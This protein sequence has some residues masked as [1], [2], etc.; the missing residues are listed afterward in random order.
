MYLNYHKKDIIW[1]TKKR[2][3]VDNKEG[4]QPPKC[5]SQKK[6]KKKTPNTM[7]IAVFNR[8]VRTSPGW[9]LVV[10][11]PSLKTIHTINIYLSL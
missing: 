2:H 4:N 9:K 8:P 1:C 6:K 11:L 10:W 7:Y 5:E 3:R